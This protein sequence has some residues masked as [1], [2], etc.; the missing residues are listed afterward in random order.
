MLNFFDGYRSKLVLQN[1]F[2]KYGLNRNK[3]GQENFIHY[4]RIRDTHLN[5]GNINIL[6]IDA[7]FCRYQKWVRVKRR[8]IKLTH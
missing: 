1:N 4:E 7:C 2:K 3:I 5:L 8:Y 6:N